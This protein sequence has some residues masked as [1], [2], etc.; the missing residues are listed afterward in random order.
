MW[1]TSFG[2]RTLAGPEA[3]LV[4]EMV[5]YLFY[6]IDVVCREADMSYEGGISVFDRLEHEQQLSLLIEGG[7]ALLTAQLP[8]PKLTAVREATVATVFEEL[9]ASIEIEIDVAESDGHEIVYWRSLTSRAYAAEVSEDE[10][11]D[12]LTPPVAQSSDLKQWRSV[13]HYLAYRILWDRDWEMA[14]V[15]MDEPPAKAR[16]LKQQMGI[17]DGYFQGIPPDPTER[18]VTLLRRRYQKLCGL[19]K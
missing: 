13:V 8:S 2:E 11:D 16:L 4:R 7:G 3:A 10:C 6:E 9:L 19:S 18:G 12:E 5:G 14:D 15:F 1:R 17:D